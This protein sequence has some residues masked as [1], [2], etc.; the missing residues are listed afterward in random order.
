MNNNYLKAEKKIDSYENSIGAMLIDRATRF[1]DRFVIQERTPDNF[2]KLTWSKLYSEVRK[3]ACGLLNQGIKKGQK[4]AVLSRDCPEILVLELA[5]M[6]IG[7]VFVP[8]YTGYYPRQI[9][10]ILFHSDPKYVVVYNNEDIEKVLSTTATGTIEKYFMVEY[11]EK[12]LESSR[13][14]DFKIIEKEED[15]IQDFFDVVNSIQPDD[16]A[17]IVY[18]SGRST[19]ISKGAEF[20]HKNILAHQSALVKE[21]GITEKDVLLSYYPWHHSLGIVE[22]FLALFAG[23]CLTIDRRPGIHVDTLAADL[24]LYKPTIYFGSGK[25]FNDLVYQMKSNKEIETAVLHKEV[26]FAFASSSPTREVIEFFKEKNVPILQGWGLT[27]SLQYVTVTTK[28]SNWESNSSGFTIPEMELKIEG[29]EN[30]I[31]VRGIGVIDKYYKDEEKSES[32]FTKDGWLR[33]GDAGKITENGLEVLGRIDSIFYLTDDE[34]TKVY[35]SKVERT[36]ENSSNFISNCVVVGE[37][38][39]FIGALIFIPENTLK[40]WFKDQNGYL[41][42]IADIVDDPD[43]IAL[44]KKEL[45]RINERN[46]DKSYYIQYFTLIE[47]PISVKR[48][49]KTSTSMVIRKQ[50]IQNYNY[51]VDAFYNISFPEFKSRIIKVY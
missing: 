22:L 7:V 42:P 25:I 20:T 41:I 46:F 30:E 44:Y 31:L 2:L 49:E 9:E 1:A 5:C 40:E 45:K 26:N 38:K 8:I 12:F 33:T 18:T 47:T 32:C 39:P 14:F 23:S 35:A 13:I 36:V 6:S 21:L 27:E 10:Y 15:N 19:G 29:E 28:N 24:A 51:L 50:V 16:P 3:V 34:K 48:G 4:I 43:V 37:F 17:L 11:D